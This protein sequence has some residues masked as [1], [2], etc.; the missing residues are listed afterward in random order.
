MSDFEND[1]MDDGED[2]DFEYEELDDDEGDVDLE[3]RYYNAKGIFMI[4][5]II[6]LDGFYF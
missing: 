2:F 3:N 1:F 5:S 6:L 4:L